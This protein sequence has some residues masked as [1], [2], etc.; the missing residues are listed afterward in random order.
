[1][2]RIGEIAKRFAINADTL[3]FYEK[4]KLLMPSVR[5]EAGYRLYTQQDAQRLSFI[6][7]A[8]SVGFSLSEIS[9]LLSI[10]LDKQNNVCSDVKSLVDIKL[11]SVQEKI[12]EL[13]HF[14]KSL[15]Q[16][17]QACCGGDI[18]AEHCTILEALESCD[19]SWRES[20]APISIN[21]EDHP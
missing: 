11:T 10:D 18:S 14:E 19:P 8:K 4:H 12:I 20:T 7:R 6:L 3:R 5:S 2:Y 9:E 17:S 15:T 13:Q 16:L 21:K 1:M